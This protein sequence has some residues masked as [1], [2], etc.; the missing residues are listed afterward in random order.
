VHLE[1]SVAKIAEPG[2]NGA[3]ITVR[4]AGR[5]AFEDAEIGHHVAIAAGLL[6]RQSEAARWLET[7]RMTRRRF[8][9]RP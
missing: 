7:P 4:L 1:S 2:T 3:S 8:D 6:D 9:R 5:R